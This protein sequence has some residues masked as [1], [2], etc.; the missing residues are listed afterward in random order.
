[1]TIGNN[2]KK[3]RETA[4]VTQSWLANKIGVTNVAVSRW[5]QNYNEPSMSN[6][7]KIAKVLKVSVAD[8]TGDSTPTTY[9]LPPNAIPI[10]GSEE[11]AFLPYRGRIHAGDPIEADGIEEIREVPAVVKRNHPQGF[12]LDV[13]GDCMDVI[14]PEGSRVVVDPTLEP[15]NGQI[16]AFMVDGEVVMRRVFKGSSALLLVPDSTNPE[17]TDIVITGDVEVVTYGRVVWFQAASE[18]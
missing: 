6:I 7:L 15:Q 2:I 9:P 4:K 3:Y 18:L 17:Y 14:Y 5:E 10:E 12:L 13:I 16:G 1:M 8:L 11:P